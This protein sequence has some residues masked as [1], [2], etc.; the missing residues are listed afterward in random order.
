MPR[1]EPSHGIVHGH[2]SGSGAPVVFLHGY[3][4]GALR[5]DTDLTAAGLGR[6]AVARPAA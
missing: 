4:M 3:L 2:E 5:P 6:D 1:T